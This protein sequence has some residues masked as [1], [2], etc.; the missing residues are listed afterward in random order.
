LLRALYELGD[1]QEVYEHATATTEAFLTTDKQIETSQVATSIAIAASRGDAALWT[2][3]KERLDQEKNPSIRRALIRALGSFRQPAEIKSSLALFLE[4]EPLQAQDFW[5]IVGPTM[6]RDEVFAIS[7]SWFKEH[8]EAIVQKLGTKSKARLP[9]VGGGFCSPEGRQ[10]V[11][12]FFST[13]EKAPA[14]TERN[15]ANTLESIDR[16]V[17]FRS[18]VTGDLREFLRSQ[19][20]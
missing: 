12:S 18:F 4:E 7:W 13:P 11:A 10:S 3:L 19:S 8:Y 9:R 5:S 15:L 20:P 16:C 6:R 17:R 1:A 14:G 2:K